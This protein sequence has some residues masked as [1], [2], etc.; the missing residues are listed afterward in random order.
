MSLS[1]KN[2]EFLKVLA[3]GC[4]L[5][6]IFFIDFYLQGHFLYDFDIH[7]EFIPLK[8]FFF[9]ELEQG[10]LSYWNPYSA[11]GLPLLADGHAGMYYPLNV[12]LYL[13]G[14]IWK[15]LVPF[16]QVHQIMAFVGV[17]Y[18][19]KNAR[20]H[21]KSAF[22]I[23]L[24]ASIAFAFSGGVV[25]ILTNYFYAL[26]ICYIPLQFLFLRRLLRSKGLRN[27]GLLSLSLAFP[28]FIGAFPYVLLSIILLA[29]YALIELLVSKRRFSRAVFLRLGASATIFA[30]LVSPQLIP[31]L[32]YIQESRFAD[33][34]SPQYL[35]SNSLSPSLLT[36]MIA[37]HIWGVNDQNN[38]SFV[39]QNMDDLHGYFDFDE[40]HNFIGL[41]C[42]IFALALLIR[43]KRL[44]K[45]LGPLV[46]MFFTPAL[47][48]LG[49]NVPGLIDLFAM[50]PF[51]NNIKDPQKWFIFASFFL[52]VMGAIGLEAALNT[53]IWRP[54]LAFLG[55]AL[56]G[57]L[58]VYFGENRDLAFQNLL[59]IINAPSCEMGT[60]LSCLTVKIISPLGH[61]IISALAIFG[62]LL[63][64][65]SKK[66]KGALLCGL[67]F[68][69]LFLME[70]SAIPRET[71]DF[72]L[73]HSSSIERAKSLS[74]RFRFM[75]GEMSEVQSLNLDHL[76]GDTGLYH[77]V[78]TFTTT[79]PF[80][81]KETKNLFDFFEREGLQEMARFERP[82]APDVLRLLGALGLKGVIGLDDK[83][84]I[85]ND[86]YPTMYFTSRYKHH[87]SEDPV[88]DY[89][90]A[91]LDGNCD[92]ALIINK[93]IAPGSAKQLIYPKNIKFSS[94]SLS[95]DIR[96]PRAGVFV[97]LDQ[98]YPGW[99]SLV[100]GK[101][102][103]LLLV[104]GMFKG[105]LLEGPGEYRI[106]FIFRPNNVRI[107]QWLGL[108]GAL[109]LLLT[110]AP[111]KYVPFYNRSSI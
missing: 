53:K 26:A 28:F 9:E 87:E 57:F 21:R 62:V 7:N 66:W 58:S 59:S 61:L 105:V 65:L 36:S 47:F 100:N 96:V 55:I 110:L 99:R 20:A 92:Q 60:L 46:I 76:G 6:F 8:K 31:T 108:L 51:L 34:S 39:D 14:P 43:R 18:F 30:L 22:Y 40:L 19:T 107:S 70:S 90:E 24:F 73:S 38:R 81:T 1:E 103:E 35:G 4:A 44:N 17:F 77:R 88:R 84:E 16:F 2:A 83:M 71:K 82:L 48:S 102:K 91:C 68:L 13:F 93:P 25:A 45:D 5:S 56:L 33:G 32:E 79:T 95:A 109:L 11:M 75:D 69:E 85:V 74:P 54:F 101:E 64:G 41:S 3:L 12:L 15:G 50:T 89:L 52:S 67:L 106:E 29:I 42:L 97:V 80:L 98:S 78:P 27:V 94:Q 37:P 104:N 23:S 111:Y 49:A 72:Y 10:R 63:T 86:S